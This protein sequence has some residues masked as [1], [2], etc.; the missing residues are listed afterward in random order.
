MALTQKLFLQISFLVLSLIAYRC[1]AQ[2]L[3]SGYVNV[4]GTKVYVEAGGKG[5]P[6][7]LVHAGFMDRR[8]WK[9]QTP[10]LLNK[11]QVVLVDLPGHGQT[12]DTMQAPLAEK[13]I[14]VVMDSLH[15]HT[16]AFAGI[17][18]GAAAVLDFA[19]SYPDKVGKL[20]LISAGLSGWEEGR[21][22]QPDTR[23]Y[24]KLLDTSLK[25][26]D[27]AAA[28]EVFTHY[29]LEG[30]KRSNVDVD[31]SLRRTVLNT[32]YYNMKQH[33]ASG[34]P[35]SSSPSAIHKLA[36]IKAPVLLIAGTE[37]MNEVLQIN[38]YLATNITGAK[39]VMVPDAGHFLN[40]ER[41]QELNKALLQF[42]GGQ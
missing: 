10:A 39:Q 20:V 14:R 23:E 41:P 13:V 31:S 6:V 26:R 38:K 5:D 32:I 33:R 21:Q 18:L 15:I 4:D 28:A 19:T 17:S 35:K 29:W 7:I 40:L 36:M 11:H 25:K 30:P 22:L 42:L 24:F 12:I 8:M 2:K 27:T 37:D 9:Y 16:A 34:W 3:L 1:D